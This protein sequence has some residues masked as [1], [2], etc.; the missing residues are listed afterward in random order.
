MHPYE[1]W[2]LRRYLANAL[3]ASRF[4]RPPRRDKDI[5]TW[6]ESHARLLGLPIWYRAVLV[7]M[8]ARPRRADQFGE[9]E[10]LSRGDDRG[11]PGAG[12]KCLAASEAPRLVG[13]SLLPDR[14]SERRPRPHGASFTD[15]PG[16]RP[17]RGRQ[18][19][20]RVRARGRIRVFPL[21]WRR[22]RRGAEL[23]A[24]RPALPAGADR[25]VRGGA[26]VGRRSAPA[27]SSEVWRAPR[28][29]PPARPTPPAPRWAGATS[30]TSARC[31]IWPRALSL[32]PASSG[33]RAARRQPALLRCAGHRKERVRQDARR[34]RRLLRPVLWRD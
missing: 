12:A 17:R 29:R 4:V 31:A 15:G 24:G 22:T 27:L 3:R 5:A 8:F 30:R 33:A 11:R 25:G 28:R 21:F 20:S 34:A 23:A 32:P 26:P 19:P 18:R 1:R 9:L 13:R 16:F 7:E 10:G 14:S 2:I 6:I